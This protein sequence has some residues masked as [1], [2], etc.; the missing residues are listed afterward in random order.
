MAPAP[1]VASSGVSGSSAGAGLPRI[2]C[3][4]VQN[5]RVVAK[6]SVYS[7]AASQGRPGFTSLCTY[8]GRHIDIAQDLSSRI[9]ANPRPAL[10]REDKDGDHNDGDAEV[11]QV[12]FL[13]Y[14]LALTAGEAGASPPQ[15]GVQ[16]GT[17]KM[18][19][20]SN[21]RAV[22][23]LLNATAIIALVMSSRVQWIGKSRHVMDRSVHLLLKCRERT[24]VWRTP[25]MQT[26]VTARC[27]TPQRLTLLVLYCLSACSGPGL[28]V[29]CLVCCSR[30][31]RRRTHK[32]SST[33]GSF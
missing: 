15:R 29:R 16:T 7:L 11:S 10:L 30:S 20:P 27:S 3:G 8:Y 31:A 4:T 18:A 21:L 17:G 24:R 32:I 19:W 22:I 13:V 2:R 12:C 14:S 1:S 26:M 25:R 5:G 9:T 28:R 33:T 6:H 23:H